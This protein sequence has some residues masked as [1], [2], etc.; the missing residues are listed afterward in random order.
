MSAVPAISFEDD[1]EAG[2]ATGE[3]MAE[4]DAGELI[5]PRFPVH[6]RDQNSAGRAGYQFFRYVPLVVLG[7]LAGT[8]AFYFV[9]CSVLSMWGRFQIQEMQSR[10]TELVAERQELEAAKRRNQAPG[11]I[12]KRAGAELQMLPAPETRFLEIQPKPEN[13]GR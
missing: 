4:E 2:D 11:L 13:R 12:L 9:V 3:P 6:T 7:M 1:W 10:Q 8:W 5:R